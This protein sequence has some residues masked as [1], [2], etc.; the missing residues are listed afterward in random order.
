MKDLI[1]LIACLFMCGASFAE[2]SVTSGYFRLSMGDVEVAEKYSKLQNVIVA[3]VNLAE[4]CKCKVTIKRPD[5]YVSWIRPAT[6]KTVS[7]DKP[8]ERENGAILTDSEIDHYVI[9]YWKVGSNEQFIIVESSS[10]ERTI[11][12]LTPGIWRF[13]VKTV[14]T[15]NLASLWSDIVEVDI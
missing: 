1:L 11:E 12:T 9:S 8:T 3:A 7:W 5:I 4:E 15:D 2:T 6:T 10:L 14:D 13:R